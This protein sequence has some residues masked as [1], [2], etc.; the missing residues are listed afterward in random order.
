LLR[1]GQ[2]ASQSAMRLWSHGLPGTLVKVSFPTRLMFYR[3]YARLDDFGFEFRT[4]LVEWNV[5]RMR[6]FGGRIALLLVELM[7]FNTMVILLKRLVRF[8]YFA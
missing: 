1:P 3:V 5:P 6:Y 2:N 4:A 7:A 8:H